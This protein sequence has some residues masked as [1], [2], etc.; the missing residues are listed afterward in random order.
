MKTKAKKYLLITIS[1][2][3]FAFP[4]T[5]CDVNEDRSPNQEIA[6]RVQSN[7]MDELQVGVHDSAGIKD[8]D[9]EESQ[10]SKDDTEIE[11]DAPVSD[12]VYEL[13]ET[14][15]SGK[16]SDG[17][18]EEN[19]SEISYTITDSSY[20][21]YATTT[22][23]IRKGPSTTYPVIGEYSI[24]QEVFVTGTCDNGWL[25]VNMNGVE[26]FCS[27]KYISAEPIQLLAPSQK[28]KP[29]AD[30]TPS[31]T[32]IAESYGGAE[33]KWVDMIN[34]SLVYV[35]SYILDA[36]IADGW[37]I[38]ATSENIGQEYFGG[39]IGSVRGVTT[40]A[41]KI[42]KIECRDVAVRTAPLHE[43]GHY[44]DDRCGWPSNSSEFIEIYNEEGGAFKA[45]IP[46]S[47]CVSSANEMFA[48]GFY[49][50]LTNPSK[51]TPRLQEFLS[52]YI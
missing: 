11:I 2:C 9:A 49:Y 3:M 40:Y 17:V 48:E 14:Y 34:S 50:Y 26:A 32:G 27:G 4:M 51:L 10:K 18:S 35:P 29:E 7:Y 39:S 6:E 47:S 5:G 37:H 8:V 23:N 21:W 13:A 44:W 52:R 20:T 38:Y 46:N 30:E 25:R 31:A 36:F 1:V 22:L 12:A 42:I 45:E 43:F 41:D 24:G 33:Q 28:S 19:L 16:N 15:E